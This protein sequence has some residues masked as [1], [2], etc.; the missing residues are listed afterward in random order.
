MRYSWIAVIL[1]YLNIARTIY[2]YRKEKTIFILHVFVKKTQK[3]P[4][5]S[6]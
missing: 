3:T 4:F 1:S 5:G 6:L 2:V